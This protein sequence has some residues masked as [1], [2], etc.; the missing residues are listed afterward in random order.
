MQESANVNFAPREY[1]AE[2]AERRQAAGQ[3]VGG[4]LEDARGGLRALAAGGRLYRPPTGKRG[5]NGE[6]F[7]LT[8]RGSRLQELINSSLPA[9]LQFRELLDERAKRR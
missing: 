5:G 8:E 9:N 6:N 2:L 3:P 4:T 7:V 1:A